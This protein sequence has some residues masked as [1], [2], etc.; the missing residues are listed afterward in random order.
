MHI[1]IDIVIIIIFLVIIAVVK[2]V[3]FI[4]E[5]KNKQNK[6]KVDILIYIDCHITIHIATFVV[7]NQTVMCLVAPYT[8][9]TKTKGLPG[10]MFWKLITINNDTGYKENNQFELLA[11]RRKFVLVMSLWP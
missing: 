2:F 1:Y 7:F 11:V 5:N 4:S 8:A 10:F 9:K 3:Y 6:K